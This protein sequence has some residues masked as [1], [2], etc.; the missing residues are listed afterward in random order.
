M[1]AYDTLLEWASELGEGP[2]E[3]WKAASADL[4]VEPNQAARGLSSL[5]HVEFDWVAS[6]FN[7]APPTAVLTLHSSGCVLITGARRRGQ[8]KALEQ[9]YEQNSDISV[10]L[11][12]PVSQPT[13]PATWLVE[14]DLADVGRF[15]GLAGMRFEID[16]GRRIAQAMPQATLE[17]VGEREH[18]DGRFPRRWFDPRRRVFCPERPGGGEEGLWWVEE[19]RR[20]AAFV[21]RRGEW[22]RVPTREY[23][24]FVAYPEVPFMTYQ[25]RLGFLTVDNKTPLPPLLA[26]A[27]TL[28]SGRLPSPEGAARHTYVNVDE[29]LAK[30]IRDRLDS[31]MDWR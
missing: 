30:L 20:E 19:Y 5:G 21:R 24:P 27:A 12:P 13:G 16:S 31:S 26:R 22:F 8:R 25:S 7:C 15:C 6:R 23:G 10:E 1:N 3:S 14:A 18:P 29:E 17:A 28:Q 11:L 9:L 2:W 4:G